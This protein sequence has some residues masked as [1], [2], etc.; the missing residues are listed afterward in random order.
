M[1]KAPL[2][3]F[4][5]G[6]FFVLTYTR[7]SGR[8]VLHLDDADGSSYNLGSNVD[9]ILRQ[10]EL[11]GYEGI[12]RDAIDRARTF[13]TVQVIPEQNRII[14]L[15]ERPNERKRNVFDNDKDKRNAKF[16]ALPTL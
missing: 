16:I 3:K 5:P 9:F 6:D 7:G 15:F 2:P 1:A 8:Y 10:F 11:W 4:I 14:N 12:A 13:R